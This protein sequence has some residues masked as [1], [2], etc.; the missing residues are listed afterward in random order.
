MVR[1]E[2]NALVW[3]IVGNLGGGKSLSAVAVAVQG[4]ID[5]YFVATNITLKL[6]ELSARLGSWVHDMYMHLDLDSP[7]FDPFKIPQ[8]SPRG[9]GG[10][11]RVLV[12]LDEVAEWFDQ[13]SNAKDPK[14]KRLW[15]WLRHSSKRSQDVFIIC[16]RQE[17]INKVVRIL[18]ARWVWVDDLAV[19]RIPVLKMR[20]PFCGGLVMQNVFD[21]VGNKIGQVSFLAKSSWGRFYDTAECL[22][23][24]GD[25]LSSVY[26]EAPPKRSR[27]AAL[28][29]IYLAS[30]V[31]LLYLTSKGGASRPATRPA[32]RTAAVAALP[33]YYIA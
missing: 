25:G 20:L 2:R 21:R 22:N 26:R 23:K 19:Y 1:L 16:Q 9:S 30:I 15:S 7:D 31:Y 29:F 28:F 3:G 10:R 6:D 12:I 24:E 11:L 27:Y 4:I 32:R 17:Y 13:Y 33:C 18:I 14:I 5:G 8:G